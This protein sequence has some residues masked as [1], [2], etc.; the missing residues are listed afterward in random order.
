MLY[1]VLP[2]PASHEVV[3]PVAIKAVLSD[4]LRYPDRSLGSE[5]LEIVRERLTAELEG[6]TGI[7]VTEIPLSAPRTSYLRDAMCVLLVFMAF[8][9]Y[10]YSQGAAVAVMFSVMAAVFAAAMGL[11]FGA[12]MPGTRRHDTVVLAG[13][14]S[15]DSAA[16]PLLV[17]AELDSRPAHIT[18]RRF[19]PGYDRWPRCAVIGAAIAGSALFYIPPQSSWAL[20]SAGGVAVLAVLFFGLH[21][22]DYLRYRNDPAFDRLVQSVAACDA[23]VAH[24]CTGQARPVFLALVAGR[25]GGFHSLYTLFWRWWQRFGRRGRVLDMAG[26]HPDTALRDDHSGGF[27]E[28]AQIQTVAKLFNLLPLLNTV[29]STHLHNQDFDTLLTICQDWSNIVSKDLIQTDTD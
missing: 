1:L 23:V 24:W 8:G 7:D 6:I 19:R 27:G 22:H 26:P 25:A 14:K 21:I 4:I 10:P 18:R 17:I 29:G 15:V 20:W 16:I 2:V 9:V 11:P 13:P 28:P 3:M 5:G 12:L